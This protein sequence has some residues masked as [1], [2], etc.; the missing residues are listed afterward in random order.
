MIRVLSFFLSIYL[1]LSNPFSSQKDS[2]KLI[3]FEGSDWCANCIRFNNTIL[4][5]T[6]FIA[7]TNAAKIEVEHIDFPQRKSLDKATKSYNAAIAEQYNF[8]GVF[9]TIV[10]TNNDSNYH[11]LQYNNET[12]EEFMALLQ[13]KIAIR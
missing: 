9:P 10:I 7:Y 4:K 1:V 13:S 3:V 8:K 5:N 12:P 11:T 6:D 2:Y